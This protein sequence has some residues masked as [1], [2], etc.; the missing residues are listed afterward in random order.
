[1]DGGP[2]TADLD[3]LSERLRRIE[4]VTDAELANL[5]VGDLLNALLDR[6]R[7]LLL[8]DTAAVLLLDP[9][10]NHLLATAARGIEEEVQ[11]GVRIP[12]GRGFAGRIAAEQRPAI[13]QEVNAT[14]VHNPLLLARGVRSLLGVPLVAGGT[15]LGVL[16][17]GTLAPRQFT[18][19][20]TALLQ[21]VADRIALATQARLSRADRIAA[22]ALQRSLLPAAL[23][24]LPGL[25]FAA[26]YVPGEGDVGGDWYDVFTLPTGHLCIIIGDVAGWGLSAAATMGRLRTV[27]RAHALDIPDPAELLRKVDQHIHHFEPAVMATGI[28]AM[29]DPESHIVELSIAGHPPPV[30]ARPDQPAQFLDMPHDL[31]LGVD[32]G[33]PRHSIR[34]NLAQG[35]SICFYT[36]GLVERRDAPLD[37]GLE[38]L[39]QAMI[40]ARAETVCATIMSR[41]IGRNPAPDDIAVL[42]LSCRHPH[43]AG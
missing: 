26:R 15:V 36:D 42:T 19:N 33:C 30:I 16:H 31:P 12:L 40:A 5:D 41:L 3:E 35:T 34:A 9:S 2:G 20:D 6:V 7:E 22:T 27:F 37:T 18:D 11:Q 23:P 43:E 1:V 25:E 29:L 17:V 38:Q 21:L 24:T 28:C 13:L 4:A 39:R 8:V 14:N 10:R 32:I